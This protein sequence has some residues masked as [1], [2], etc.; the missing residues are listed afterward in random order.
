M[1][2]IYKELSWQVKESVKISRQSLRSYQ[3]QQEQEFSSLQD[4]FI[5]I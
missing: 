2:Q 5:V 1:S 4:V 3:V